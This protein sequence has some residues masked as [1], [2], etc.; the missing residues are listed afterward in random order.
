MM[1]QP[2]DLQLV[3]N[4]TVMHSRTSFEDHDDLALRLDCSSWYLPPIFTWL[5]EQGRVKVM[6]ML[7]TF[8]CGIGMLILVRADEADA[9]LTALQTGPEPDAWIAGDLQ[10]RSDGPSMIFDHLDRLGTEP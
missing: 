6:E 2:G 9:V 1:M 7:R 10:P 3:N 8:N 4:Y 5:Q